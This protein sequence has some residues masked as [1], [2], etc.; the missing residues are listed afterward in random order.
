MS[1]IACVNGEF[2]ELRKAQVPI[3]DRGFLYGDGIFETLRARH[4]Q[5]FRLRPH[6]QRLQS[7]AEELGI[8]LPCSLTEI[9]KLIHQTLE[10]NNLN[11]SVIRLQLTR[12]ESE[13][14]LLP[15]STE[16]PTFVIVVRPFTP[17][18]EKF[19]SDGVYICTFPDSAS[20]T[21]L[22]ERR[23]KTTNY[24]VNIMLKK[25]AEEMKCFEA[26]A[27]DSKGHL[28]EGTV[29]NIMLVKENAV[30]TPPIGKYVLDGITRRVVQEICKREK[31]DFRE[32]D[33]S[34]QAA[35][36]ADELFLTNTGIGVLPVSQLNGKPVGSG[37]PGGVTGQLS[38]LFLKLFD[39]ELGSC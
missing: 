15:A 17:V 35:R 3:L 39:T 21:S 26:V 22:G 8:A 24:L 20:A 18:S 36:D 4:N 30:T 7:S 28:T 13:P 14:G 34:M 32:H 1:L 12:G 23:L 2:I 31:I 25:K 16:T 38:R 37:K 9:E 6:L 29:S 19:Y 27:L 33:L 11:E 10:K 5:V